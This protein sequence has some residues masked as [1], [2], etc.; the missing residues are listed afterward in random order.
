MQISLPILH[1]PKDGYAIDLNQL[2]DLTK[3]F[4]KRDTEH[5]N[6]DYC[7]YTFELDNTVWYYGMGRY[8]DL[9]KFDMKSWIKSRPFSHKYDLLANTIDSNW[10]C[11][12]IGMGMTSIEAH[13]LEA[14]LIK[15]D[16]R[17]LSK[18]NTMTWDRE[19][20]INKKR[21]LKWEMLIA[22]YLNIR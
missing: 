14:N 22:E 3:V 20:L 18:V 21:E 7:V 1:H 16:S 11:V 12:I 5:W 17:K 15:S 6:R 13:V 4:K 2:I 19:S 8:Y 10:T 9:T